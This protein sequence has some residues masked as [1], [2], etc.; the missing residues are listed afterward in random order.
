M[1]SSS[2]VR[3]TFHLFSLAIREFRLFSLNCRDFVISLLGGEKKDLFFGCHFA[4]VVWPIVQAASGL[5][6]HRSVSDIFGTWLRCLSKDFKPLALRVVAT[7]RSCGNKLHI[8]SKITC[9]LFTQSSY[10]NKLHIFW[11]QRPLSSQ[12][13][14]HAAKEFFFLQTY[15]R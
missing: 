1:S 6:Q 7:C 11:S 10:G 15:G 8:F 5:Y 14:A 12:Q 2:P 4:R 13:L 9:T 3:I